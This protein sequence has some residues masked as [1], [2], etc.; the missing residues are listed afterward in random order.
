MNKPAEPEAD[1][2]DP[3]GDGFGPVPTEA[4][5][6]S[7]FERN[8]ETIGQLVQEALNE[9]EPPTTWD[10]EAIKAE[11]REQLRKEGR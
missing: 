11:V 5:M 4:E 3:I 9:T 8:R 10:P 1:D 2:F 7:W 6:D